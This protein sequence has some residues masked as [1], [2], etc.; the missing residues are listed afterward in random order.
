MMRQIPTVT[1]N[2]LIINILLFF[3]SNAIPVLDHNL[4]AFYIENGNFKIWQVI[5]HMFMHGSIAHLFFNMMALYMFGSV[6][7]SY[8]GPKKFLNYY[9]ICGLGAFALQ[10]TFNYIE[11][12]NA[13]NHLSQAQIGQLLDPNI[14]SIRYDTVEELNYSKKF[15]SA[16]HNG[17]VGASGCIFGLLIAYGMMFPNHELFL[18]FIPVPIKAKWFVLGYGA[19]EFFLA[20]QNRPD[21]N[22]AHFAHLGGML[23]GYI[24]LKIWQRQGKLYN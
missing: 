2:I 1:K 24:M 14:T 3:A 4:T 6:L 17:L 9:I 10:Q 11:I 15:F 19:V 18:M 8:W 16:Y 7:E 23:V 12:H 21:D 5:T 13:I 20:F 22:I